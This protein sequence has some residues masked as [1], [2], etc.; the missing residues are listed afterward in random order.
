MEEQK[1][2][3]DIDFQKYWLILKRH[4]LPASGVW[5]LTILIGI[6]LALFS[7]KTF[8]AY[9]KLKFKKENTISGLVTEAGEKIGKLD[10]LNNKDTPVDT[11]AEVISS[12][13]S[14]NKVIKNL[15]LTDEE[16]KPMTYEDFSKKLKIKGIR[17]TDILRV[18][19]RSPKPKQAQAIVDELMKVYLEDNVGFNRAE[20]SAARKF[21]IQQLP[22]TEEHVIQADANLRNFKEKYQIVDLNSESR[23]AVTQIGQLDRQIDQVQAE[24]EKTNGRISSLEGK[25]GVDSRE[26]LALNTLNDSPAI[27]RLVRKLKDVEDS[28]A[29]ERSRFQEENPV[30]V[31]LKSEKEALEAE[32]KTRVGETLGSDRQISTRI[33][34]T[35]DVQKSL[36]EQ[37]VSSEAEK[38]SLSKELNSLVA[39]QRARKQRMSVLPELEK[40]QRELERKLDAAQASYKNLLKNLEQVKIAENQT[41]GNAQ[42]ISPAVVAQNPV[43][44]SKKITIGGGVILGGLFYI[45]TAFI[46]E[47]M[48]PSVK[49]SKEAR[50]LMGY[51]VLGMIPSSRKKALLPSSDSGISAEHQIIEAPHSVS[52]EAYKMLQTKLR[53]LNSNQNKQQVIVVTSSVPREGK[54]TVAANLAAATAEMGSRVLLID[55]DMHHPRQQDIWNLSNEVGLNEVLIDRAELYQAVKPVMPNLDILS[56][57]N[58]PANSLALLNSEQMNYVIDYAKHKYDFVVIDT[59]PILLLADVLTL[60]K[61]TDGI[62]MVVRPGVVDPAS[63]VASRELLEQSGQKVLGLVVNDVI[64]EYEP[65]SYLRYAKAYANSYGSDSSAIVKY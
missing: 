5:G 55:A 37:L 15:K 65:D 20:A 61:H 17:G 1:R 50:N 30:I 7:A 8:E 54:S 40:Q 48:D 2:T 45:M 53:F 63:A 13:P 44:L 14:V 62:L 42:I 28:L 60:S 21:I 11:E 52:S 51:K 38:R 31:N 16:G 29:S 43:S 34:Q 19:Y 32:L 24:L 56:S 18:A 36:T 4:W 39:A 23:L 12:L 33:L 10:T 25:L 47:L 59:P 57:G 35:G 46:L 64:V 27:Q 26:A 22:K 9:G 41:F 3:E 49:T 6:L 58:L